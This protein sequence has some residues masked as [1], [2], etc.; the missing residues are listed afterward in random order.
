LAAIV[1]G[2]VA[3]V[4]FGFAVIRGDNFQQQVEVSVTLLF[5][6]AALLGVWINPWFIPAAFLAH[7]LWDYAHHHRAN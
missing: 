1:M 7:G 3:G 6:I 5:V 4:Y 2:M